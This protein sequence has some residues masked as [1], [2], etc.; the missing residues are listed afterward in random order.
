MRVGE[1][2]ASA[3]PQVLAFLN[4]EFSL[5]RRHTGGTWKG[6]RGGSAA[7][8][9]PGCAGY[10]WNFSAMDAADSCSAATSCGPPNLLTAVLNSFSHATGTAAPW[11]S[12]DTIVSVEKSSMALFWY[13]PNLSAGT[14]VRA[15]MEPFAAL[16]A[17]WPSTLEI[18]VSHA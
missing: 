17:C 12:E 7:P 5:C 8:A 10:C 1:I 3:G 14:S 15:G 13:S 9:R 11:A 2:R 18:V 4:I 6:G 16:K